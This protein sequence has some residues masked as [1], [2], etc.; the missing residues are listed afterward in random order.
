MKQIRDIFASSREKNE[1]KREKK[2]IDEKTILFL[3]EK[4][5]VSQYGIRGRENIIPKAFKEKKVYFSCRSSLWMNELWINRDIFVEKLNSELG[6]GY[7]SD[8]KTTEMF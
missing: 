1:K 6:K 3:A 7:V 2:P 5:I 4:V 8:I